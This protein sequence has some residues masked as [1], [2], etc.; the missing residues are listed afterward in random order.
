MIFF[1]KNRE[2]PYRSLTCSIP[3]AYYMRL[4]QRPLWKVGLFC[5][6]MVAIEL[7]SHQGRLDNYIDYLNYLRWNIE[8]RKQKSRIEFEENFMREQPNNMFNRYK[9][10]TLSNKSPIDVKEDIISLIINN[11]LQV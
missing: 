11:C 1:F 6:C 3:I 9:H 7:S 8:V 2:I 5:S 10:I 4:L